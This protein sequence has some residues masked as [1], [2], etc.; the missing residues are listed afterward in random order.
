MR[1]NFMGVV[2]GTA[3]QKTVKVR[4]M[5][6][7]VHPI[8]RKTY[9]SFKNY[10]VHDEASKCKLGDV[11]R[12]EA[13]RPVSARKHFSVAEIVAASKVWEHTK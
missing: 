3:M 13:C 4:V 11:V 2:V 9:K 12:I 1:Q 7:K 10:L 5:S 8:V 6:Q